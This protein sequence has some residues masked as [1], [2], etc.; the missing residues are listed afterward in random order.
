MTLP[1]PARVLLLPAVLVSLAFFAPTEAYPQRGK[2]AQ[3]KGEA[4]ALLKP[5]P[6][7]KRPD[8]PPSKLP[9]EFVKGERIALVGNSTAERMNLYGHFETLLHLR[10][11]DKELVVR[12]F[13]RPADDVAVRQRSADYTTLD[14][15]I[16][17]FGP[18]TFLCFFGFNE[19]FQGPEGVEKFKADYEKFLDEYT[20]KYPRDDAGSKPRFVLVSPIAYEPPAKN[21]GPSP[22]SPADERFLP[23]GT[24][25]NANLKLYADAVKA[26]AAKR[27]LAFVDL[28]TPTRGRSRPSPGCSTRSTAAT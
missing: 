18:D 26:V 17:A 20:Q 28:F 4:D 8:L 12:N 9:L 21:R 13:G 2:K 22:T 19:S 11:P 23:D 10:F 14:D 7:P 3:P 25:E 27:N 1:R 15:P 5:K 16:H 24:K 6:R